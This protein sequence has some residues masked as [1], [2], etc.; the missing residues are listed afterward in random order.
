MR[1][2][3]WG[4]IDRV[5]YDADAFVIIGSPS[6]QFMMEL[7]KRQ[8]ISAP[9]CYI[10]CPCSSA[11]EGV[12]LGQFPSERGYKKLLKV[13]DAALRGEPHRSS[14]THSKARP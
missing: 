10:A 6:E 5:V 8:E 13:V 14:V 7:A 1:E 12:Q 11:S 3:R 9:I 4:D 2:E